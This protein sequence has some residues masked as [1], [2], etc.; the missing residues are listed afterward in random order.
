MICE[1][2]KKTEKASL[3]YCFFS[4]V[5]QRYIFDDGHGQSDLPLNYWFNL[6]YALTNII[7]TLSCQILCSVATIEAFY[8]L[9]QLMHQKNTEIA[10]RIIVFC[11]SNRDLLNSC[12]RNQLLCW[13]VVWATKNPTRNDNQTPLGH[14]E[15]AANRGTTQGTVEACLTPPSIPILLPIQTINQ[16]MREDPSPFTM[17]SSN[18]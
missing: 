6:S 12:K 4:H 18:A 9:Q 8:W 3:S 15:P 13:K 1:S 14:S 5:A 2:C 16:M 10:S 7:T 17:P 11:M